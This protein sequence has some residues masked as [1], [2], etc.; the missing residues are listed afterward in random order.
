M[1]WDQHCFARRDEL[2][3]RFGDNSARPQRRHAEVPIPFQKGMSFSAEGG[4]S[5]GYMSEAACRSLD[6]LGQ[7]HVSGC[8][9]CHSRFPHGK[10]VGHG[11]PF[12]TEIPGK[13]MT[14]CEK[15]PGRHIGV[16]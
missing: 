13:A 5:T 12:P 9:S 16:A 11:F 10:T 1:E 6:Q 15:S 7:L 14:I 8:L 4:A 3:R 2:L